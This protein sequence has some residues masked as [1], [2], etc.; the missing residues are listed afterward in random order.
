MGKRIEFR[1]SIYMGRHGL[2]VYSNYPKIF[3]ILQSGSF[4]PFIPEYRCNKIKAQSG[5]SL[6]YIRD[7]VSSARI[8]NNKKALEIKSPVEEIVEAATIP[9]RAHYLLEPQRQRDSIITTQGAGV[10]KKNN[11]VLIMGKRGSGKSS[12]T[13]EL[14]R[15]YDYKL[16]GNDLV[17]IGYKK[18]NGYLY[19]GSKVFTLRYTTVKHYNT[20][21]RKYFK[22]KTQDE[23]TNK[24]NVY[25][26]NLGISIQKEPVNITKAFYVHL[27]NNKSAPLYIKRIGNK[28]TVYMGRLFLYEALSRYIRGVCIPIVRG[29]QFYLGDYLPS[30][31]K[32]S[33]HKKRVRLIEWL[34]KDL[35]FYYITG[36]MNAI[37]DYINAEIK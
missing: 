7:S 15:N 13:L 2:D 17:L 1:C 26:K 12:I 27:K 16:I 35:G 25:P 19:G 8:F 28:D 34:I 10:S 36:S 22:K 20:D 30:L 6:I 14:C 3:D 11:A 31:D 18:N 29:S 5:Y 23:W 21:L 37:C 9:F 32:P 4:V 24:I 33:Y